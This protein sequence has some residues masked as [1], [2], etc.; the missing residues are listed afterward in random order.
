MRPALKSQK[1]LRQCI[2][3]VPLVMLGIRSIVGEDVGCT[4]AEVVHGTTLG[5]PDKPFYQSYAGQTDCG[6]TLFTQQSN[7]EENLASARK[8]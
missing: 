8:A 4:A 6:V 3:Q 7:S 5:L 2:E 1:N